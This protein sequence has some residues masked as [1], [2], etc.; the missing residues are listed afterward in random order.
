MAVVCLCS[1]DCWEAVAGAA[2]E[3]LAGGGGWRRGGL[4]M[5]VTW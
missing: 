4:L 5:W 2:A 3:G 1:D